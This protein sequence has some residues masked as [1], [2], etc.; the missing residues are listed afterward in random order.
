MYNNAQA[1]AQF[2]V[3]MFHA[4]GFAYRLPYDTTVYT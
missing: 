1:D 3:K 2:N 4:Y